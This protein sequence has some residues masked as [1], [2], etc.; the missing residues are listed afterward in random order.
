M[1]QNNNAQNHDANSNSN[2]LKALKHDVMYLSGL[3]VGAGLPLPT[4]MLES[5][6]LKKA[7]KELSEKAKR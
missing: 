4:K 2:E 7:L 5:E 1:K 3:I 6:F